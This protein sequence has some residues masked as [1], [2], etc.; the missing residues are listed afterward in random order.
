VT[1][2]E[3]EAVLSKPLRDPSCL[4]VDEKIAV[5]RW[6]DG[7][8][9]RGPELGVVNGQ[10]CVNRY[11]VADLVAGVAKPYQIPFEQVWNGDKFADG[12][13]TVIQQKQ[14]IH[15]QRLKER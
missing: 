10:P 14:L 9:W 11:N 4:Y 6:T 13:L 2:Q 5:V 8:A 1:K 12:P 15:D 3:V 7:G